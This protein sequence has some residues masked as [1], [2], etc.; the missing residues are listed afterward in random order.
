MITHQQLRASEED[1]EHILKWNCHDNYM[2]LNSFK[3]LDNL[4]FIQA[5]HQVQQHP[6]N[7]NHKSSIFQWR[8]LAQNEALGWTA[9]LEWPQKPKLSVCN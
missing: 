6:G 4:A 3:I 9:A 7:K 2:N 5:G 8:K 1:P